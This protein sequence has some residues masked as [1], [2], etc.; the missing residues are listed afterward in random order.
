MSWQRLFWQL[1]T[2]W[3]VCLADL[4]RID[5]QFAE[6]RAVLDSS[7]SGL[8][9]TSGGTTIYCEVDMGL[10]AA[11]AHGSLWHMT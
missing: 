5:G 3:H 7:S 10:I 9:S 4:S 8:T 2:A 1:D 6:A 11:H